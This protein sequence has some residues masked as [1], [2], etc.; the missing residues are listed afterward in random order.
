MPI[1]D[2]FRSFKAYWIVFFIPLVVISFSFLLK[3]ASGPY[4]QFP[5][6]CYGYL[7]SSLSLVKG[8]SPTF[9][10]Q[11]GTSV[12][13]LGALVVSLLNIGHSSAEAVH[14]ALLD[15]DFYLNAINLVMIV[16]AFLTSTILG[17]YVYRQTNDKLAV[18]L[19]QLPTLSFLALRS[20]TF[21]DYVLPVVTNVTP[22]PLLIS[23]SC[24]FNFCFLKLFFAKDKREEVV[25]TLLLAFI[26]G[27]G[28]STRLVFAP[29]LVLPLIVCRGWM[30]SLFLFASVISC[31]FW[32]IS[33]IPS[34]GWIWAW[35]VKLV[36]HV[37]EYG[38]GDKGFINFHQY[39][40]DWHTILGKC[41]LLI[42]FALVAVVISLRQLIK[43]RSH[44]GAIFVLATAFCILLQLAVIAKHY[45][46]HYL[47]S[48]INLFS[49]LFVL[50]YLNCKN[51]SSFFKGVVFAYIMV[52]IVQAL[53]NALVYDKKLTGYTQDAVRFNNMIHAK[54][55]NFIFIGMFP[56]PMANPEAAFFWGN[57]RDNRQQDELANL[58]PKR[59]A[60]FGNNINDYAPYVYGIYSIKQRVW[61]DDLIKNG[62]NVIFVAPKGYD[63]SQSPYTVLPI[64]QAKFAAAYL[65][66]GS[67]EKQAN[68]LLEV[69]FRLL[70][71]GDYKDAFACA[72][73]SR[74]LHYQ[75]VEKADIVLSILYPHI[76]H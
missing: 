56:M 66:V 2:L 62:S 7:T 61:A 43:D 19:S 53:G 28:V 13:L 9:N 10:Y 15:P 65:L 4:W 21:Y 39:L 51:K 34:Y 49:P 26:S 25:L 45:D 67:T 27:L 75:P 70:K 6:P 33:I 74:E 40:V 18:L 73:K 68:E 1:K 54:Y 48:A 17:L 58:Y 30:K 8:F 16:L 63:F 44:K 47:V 3:F 57:D 42:L 41:T 24:L 59:L 60:Y 5:D 23:V 55:P 52:F 69:S 32:T 22:E 71:A 14:R 38:S 46:E 29:F 20:Y 37:G 64:E 72:L 12:E 50:F 35:V 76:K 36:T 11:P 31:F